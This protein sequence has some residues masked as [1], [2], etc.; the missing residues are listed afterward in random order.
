MEDKDQRMVE[1]C[2]IGFALAIAGD[3][4]WKRLDDAQKKNVEAYLGSMNEKDMPNTNW[5]VAS[6]CLNFFEGYLRSVWPV[7]KLF[8][9]LP[10]E[11]LPR[12]LIPTPRG[13]SRLRE[14]SRFFHQ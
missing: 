9:P 6:E 14:N 11:P 7:I 13:A 4:F 3:Y 2:P 1:A 12:Q 10:P 8:Y 5:Y